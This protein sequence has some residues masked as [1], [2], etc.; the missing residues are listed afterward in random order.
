MEF[1]DTHCHLNFNAYL[2]DIDDV[3]DRAIEAGVGQIIVPGLNLESSREVVDLAAKYDQVFAAVGVHPEDVESFD[4]NQL[5]VFNDLL[6]CEKVVAIGEIGLDFYHRQDKNDLQRVV[7]NH[8]LDIAIRHQKPVILHSRKALRD[9]FQIVEEKFTNR[10]NSKIH[11]IFHAFEGNFQDA[12]KAVNLGF[13]IG[14]GGPIT[15]KNAAEKHEVFSKIGLSNIVL[16]TDGPFLTPQLYRGKRNEPS[17]IPVIAKR[18][19]EL[20]HCDIK[21]VADRTTCNAKTIFNWKK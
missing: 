18:L 2:E 12:T 5:S 10:Q 13:Y 19:A 6:A 21:E 8:F 16:E 15:Y 3:I 9:L 4:E 14:A 7:L 17:Y 1:V 11:G 20:Q